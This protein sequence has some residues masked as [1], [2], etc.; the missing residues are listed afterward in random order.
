ME[1]E[2]QEAWLGV[3]EDLHLFGCSLLSYNEGQ[4]R[5]GLRPPLQET[6]LGA[7]GGATVLTGPQCTHLGNGVP[8]SYLPQVGAG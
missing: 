3:Q 2:A 7:L 6:W 1:T 5:E 8:S 4:R